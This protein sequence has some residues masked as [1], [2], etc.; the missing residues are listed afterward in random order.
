MLCLS[1]FELYSRWVPLIL[2]SVSPVRS[3]AMH[4]L[5]CIM[6]W[7]PYITLCYN[8]LF[9]WFWTIFSL[10]APDPLICITCSLESNA[11]F[12][13]HYVMVALHYSMLHRFQMFSAPGTI[14]HGSISSRLAT[15]R[16][17]EAARWQLLYINN[18]LLNWSFMFSI[19]KWHFQASYNYSGTIN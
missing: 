5:S 7:L 13:L 1:G 17:S 6:S 18:F 14:A 15:S 4:S 2:W 3:K 11:F 8:A 9:K 19:S 16:L 12:V 10:G